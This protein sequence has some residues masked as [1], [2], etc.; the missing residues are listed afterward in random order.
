[1]KTNHS[2]HINQYH[3]PSP[4]KKRVEIRQQRSLW[5][6]FISDS[7]V[8]EIRPFGWSHHFMTSADH[9]L[10]SWSMIIWT[11]YLLGLFSRKSLGKMM[12]KQLH[13]TAVM[14]AMWSA[15]CCGSGADDPFSCMIQ[16]EN[17]VRQRFA[18]FLA[19]TSCP[20][21]MFTQPTNHVIHK[22]QQCLDLWNGDTTSFSRNL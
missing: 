19:K 9:I 4:M 14:L 2:S 1:M 8:S 20:T 17:I 13:I 6:R 5:P 3:V 16:V 11:Q 22:I 15:R 21:A 10:S 12:A 7:R 18:T